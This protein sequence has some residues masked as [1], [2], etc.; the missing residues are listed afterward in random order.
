MAVYTSGDTAEYAANGGAYAGI[1][2]G[3]GADTRSRA[4]ADDRAGK[5]A[6]LR[7]VHVGA[8]RDGQS[9]GQYKS[10]NEKAKL[11]DIPPENYLY[12]WVLRGY[13]TVR[14]CAAR[15]EAICLS[16]GVSLGWI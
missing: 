15:V 13:L 11:H 2:A 6:L 1:A 5:A 12:A 7:F 8:G 9:H 10:E 14:I 4:G 16:A 3:Q